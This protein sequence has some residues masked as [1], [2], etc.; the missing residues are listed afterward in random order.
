MCSN[1]WCRPLCTLTLVVVVVTSSVF[2]V[3]VLVDALDSSMYR[4]AP[5]TG[6]A[7]NAVECSLC[8]L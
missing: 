5:S 2:D 8:I 3:A 4:C 1:V 7:S 6:A